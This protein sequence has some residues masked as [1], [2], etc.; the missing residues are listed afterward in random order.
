MGTE[1]GKNLKECNVIHLHLMKFREDV[2][3]Q[4]LTQEVP[5][6]LL[7]KNMFRETA[8]SK[9]LSQLLE[10]ISCVAPSAFEYKLLHDK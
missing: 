4:E 8:G 5:A 3:C 9:Q 7:G 1:G 2:S 10:L 6:S